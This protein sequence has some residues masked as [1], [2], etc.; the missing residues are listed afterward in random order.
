MQLKGITMKPVAKAEAIVGGGD[1]QPYRITILTDGLIRFE[2]A[3]DCVFED[4]A[5]TFATCRELPVPEF[6]VIDKEYVHHPPVYMQTTD[7]RQQ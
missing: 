6:R 1:N 2:Y 5:S 7:G 3:A 4:R